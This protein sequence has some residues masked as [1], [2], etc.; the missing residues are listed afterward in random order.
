MPFVNVFFG[1]GATNKKLEPILTRRAK[2]YISSVR[3]LSVYPSHFV[4]VYSWSVRCSR[5]SQK[6]IKKTLI[7]E[8]QSLSKSSILIRLQNSSRVLVVISSTPMPIC[9]LFHERLANNGKI[10]TFTGYRSLMLLCTGFLEPRK[11]RLGPSNS[12][13]N[14]KNFICSLSMSILIAFGTIRS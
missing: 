6:S 5:R 10:T 3:K 7:S 9:N 11:S 2:A 4:A 12:T 8:V 13:F 1:A 14:A